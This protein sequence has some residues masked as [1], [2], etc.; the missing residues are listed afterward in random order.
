[1]VVFSGFESK[2]TVYVLFFLTIIIAQL[3]RSKQ[4][5]IIYKK[6]EKTKQKP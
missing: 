4:S 5:M 6:E 1:M 2:S 3:K